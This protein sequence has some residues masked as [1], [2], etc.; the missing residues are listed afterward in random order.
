MHF[1]KSASKLKRVDEIPAGGR[2]VQGKEVVEV[3]A[4]DQ[5]IGI[6]GIAHF[7]TGLTDVEGSSGSKSRSRKGGSG[8]PQSTNTAKRK[9][10]GTKTSATRTAAKRPASPSGAKTKS[11]ASRKPASASTKT[12]TRK[13]SQAKTDSAVKEKSVK[14]SPAGRKNTKQPARKKPDQLELEI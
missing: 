1:L 5:V 13:T 7:M 11:A 8:E 3:K 14:K 2:A 9:A 10:G 4:G 12:T 6:T